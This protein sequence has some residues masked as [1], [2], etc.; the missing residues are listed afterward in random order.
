MPTVVTIHGAG[1]GGWAW[2]PVAERLREQGHRVFAVTLTGYGDRRHLASPAVTL[3][4]HVQDVAALIEYEQL[5]E[6]W[7]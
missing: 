1:D 4:T 3:A 7:L 2:T 6:V 5:R